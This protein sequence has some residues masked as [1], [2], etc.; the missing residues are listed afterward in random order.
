M[1]WTDAGGAR[2]D[3]GGAHN[4]SKAGMD[5]AVSPLSSESLSELESAAFSSS[6]LPLGVSMVQQPTGCR[7]EGKGLC[8]R[9]EM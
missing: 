9:K 8:N 6:P 3:E 7:C 1:G 2:K 4:L 5:V